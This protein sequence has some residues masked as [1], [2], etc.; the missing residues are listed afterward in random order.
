MNSAAPSPATLT[1]VTVPIDALYEDPANARLHGERNLDAIM[2]SLRCFGQVE[3]LVVRKSDRRIIGGNG[4][5]VAMKALGWTECQVVEVDVSDT[6]AT[7]LGI[8]LNRTAELAEWDE[9]TLA[10]LMGSLRDD[11]FDLSDLGF[12]EAEMRQ[13]AAGLDD[14]PPT[15]ELAE[16]D[17]PEPPAVAHSKPG[18]LWLLGDHRL[19]CGSSTS[20]EDVRRLMAGERAVLFATDPPYLVGYDGTNHP[21][22]KANKDHSASYGVTWDDADAEGN[23]DLW[24]R[25]CEVARAEA[26][27][28][29]AAWYCWYASVHH[30]KLQA[31]WEK[32]GAFVHQ[33][34][35]WAKASGVL[36]YSWFTWQHEPCLMGWVRP[37]K[38]P[39]NPGKKMLGTLWS[40]ERVRGGEAGDHPTPKPVQVFAIPMDQHTTQGEICYEPFSGSGTQIVAAEQMGRRCY[41]MEIEPRYVDVAVRRWCRLTGEAAIREA[42]GT[43]FPMGDDFGAV[44]D[45]A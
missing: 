29:D 2:A 40:L 26:I 8:A 6:Q 27:R 37:H 38:P 16:D 4:R 11:G 7:A 41:A 28:E 44:D 15:S 34:I 1:I 23:A 35:I 18:D 3:P 45:A 12:D 30:T 42:D 21:K 32:V 43:A 10:R 22:G 25:F 20:P 19:L 5:H 31:V 9:G 24:L 33:Q 17:A 39:R 14:A 13:L 36:T